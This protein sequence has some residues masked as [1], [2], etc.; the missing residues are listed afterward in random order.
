MCAQIVLPPFV[1]SPL[2]LTQFRLPSVTAYPGIERIL[3]TYQP[4]AGEDKV[5]GGIGLPIILPFER[6][7]HLPADNA[8]A[9]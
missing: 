6:R 4:D 2:A 1:R 9:K 3:P 7:F 8:A 5:M